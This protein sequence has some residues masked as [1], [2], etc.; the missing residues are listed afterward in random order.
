MNSSAASLF[1]F[2]QKFF[3]WSC[4]FRSFKWVCHEVRNVL[5]FIVWSIVEIGG[6][7]WTWRPGSVVKLQAVVA[8]ESFSMIIYGDYLHLPYKVDLRSLG[9]WSVTVYFSLS[10]LDISPIFLLLRELHLPGGQRRIGSCRSRRLVSTVQN[11]GRFLLADQVA[12]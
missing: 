12:F 9:L 11:A 6:L 7:R 2:R 10:V 1:V 3:S 4:R 5:P 8:K